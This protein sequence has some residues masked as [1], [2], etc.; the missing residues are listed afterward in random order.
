MRSSAETGPRAGTILA[1]DPNEAQRQAMASILGDAGFAVLEA[2][3]GD[4]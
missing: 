3:S 1:A 4:L 2:A